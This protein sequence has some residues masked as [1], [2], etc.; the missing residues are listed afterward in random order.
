MKFQAYT[1]SWIDTVSFL[2]LL[3]P[4]TIYAEK[5]RVLLENGIYFINSRNKESYLQLL[6][7]YFD[8][9]WKVFNIYVIYHTIMWSKPYYLH[10]AIKGNKT[11]RG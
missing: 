5:I 9:D 2:L 6:N 3:V 1:R 7:T 10:F 4:Y 8:P 11:Q